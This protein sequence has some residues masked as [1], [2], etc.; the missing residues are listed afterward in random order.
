[1]SFG[2]NNNVLIAIGVLIVIVAI[3]VG[4]YVY[5]QEDFS[6]AI[7]E[8]F[9][10]TFPA[11]KKYPEYKSP[12]KRENFSLVDFGT[13]NRIQTPSPL[14]PSSVSPDSLVPPVK[15]SSIS[16]LAE[17][18]APANLKVDNTIDYNTIQGNGFMPSTDTQ[19]QGLTSTNKINTNNLP[20]TVASSLLPVNP[21]QDNIN[22]IPEDIRNSL[23]NQRFLSASAQIGNPTSNNLRNRTHDIRRD[24]KIPLSDNLPSVWN[25]STIEPDMYQQPVE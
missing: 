5:T 12:L 15:G 13:A 16:A 1:M 25:I 10:L 7:T 21:V 4:V 24:P 14:V 22:N 17:T 9:S 11:V 18:A 20:T 3:G 8:K 2:I 23:E 19:F 6:N